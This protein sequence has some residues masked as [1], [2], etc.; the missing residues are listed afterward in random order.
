MT[1]VLCRVPDTLQMLSAHL[2]S[3]QTSEVK[4][5]QQEH[6]VHRVAVGTKAGMGRVVP[7]LCTADTQEVIVR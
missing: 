4:R 3:K 2:L 5:G 1:L 7:F 6:R